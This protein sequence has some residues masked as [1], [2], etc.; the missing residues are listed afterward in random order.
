MTI[1]K[2]SSSISQEMIH[3]LYL[4]VRQQSKNK[5]SQ[6]GVQ[7]ESTCTQFRH[8]PVFNAQY[9]SSR[10]SKLIPSPMPCILQMPVIQL[11][12]HPKPLF[13][14]S[15]YTQSSYT[16]PTHTHNLK[17]KRQNKQKFS[18]YACLKILKFSSIKKFNVTLLQYQ[19]T[20]L[21]KTNARGTVLL[22]KIQDD[23][24]FS[25]QSKPI[26]VLIC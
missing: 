25:L 11:S 9:S 14:E 20:Q 16:L 18:A 22:L 5:I 19:V 2:N 26:A 7:W 4:Q 24:K 13:S 8:E 3:A 17:I 6:L 1:C 23:Q 12:G 21:P 15:I 10:R